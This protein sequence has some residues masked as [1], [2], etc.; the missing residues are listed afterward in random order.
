ME[1]VRIHVETL[2]M[3]IGKV[4]YVRSVVLKDVRSVLMGKGI[5]KI[6]YKI[7]LTTLI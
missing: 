7:S 1:F 5:A 3:M 6:V 4:I 2:I